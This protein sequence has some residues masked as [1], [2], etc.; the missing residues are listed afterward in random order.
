MGIFDASP[1]PSEEQ[2]FAELSQALTPHGFMV[3]P[4]SGGHEIL[5]RFLPLKEFTAPEEY[6]S[7]VVGRIEGRDVGVTEYRYSSTDNE[8]NTSWSADYVAVVLDPNIQGVA[9][10]VNDWKHGTGGK[11]LN[12]ALWIPPFTIVKAIQLIFDSQNPDLV[13]GHGEFD[14]RYKVHAESKAVAESVFHQGFREALLQMDFRG[15]LEVRHGAM[16]FA[17][18]DTKFALD[19]L[20]KTLGHVPLLLAAALNRTPQGYR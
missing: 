3:Q 18:H 20:M 4:R 8:G 6:G 7:S 14:S 16:L 12:A 17:L 2:F 5:S 9:S 19:G 10:I 1:K 11:I 13:L 15:R